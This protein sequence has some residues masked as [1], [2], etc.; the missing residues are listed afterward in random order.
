MH[1]AKANVL[2]CSERDTEALI[3]LKAASQLDHQNAQIQLEIGDV[4]L[5]NLDLPEEALKHYQKCIELDPV[6]VSAYVRL[7]QALIE[8]GEADQAKQAIEKIRKIAPRHPALPILQERA[9]K[10]SNR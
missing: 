9:Q 4:C 10:L 5:R 2:L 6:F 8:R 3:E 7:A 1:L